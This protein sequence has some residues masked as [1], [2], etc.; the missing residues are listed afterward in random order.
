MDSDVGTTVHG[1]LVTNIGPRRVHRVRELVTALVGSEAD[2][3]RVVE[4]GGLVDVPGGP[5]GASAT[6]SPFTVGVGR[7]GGLDGS[8]GVLPVDSVDDDGRGGGRRGQGCGDGPVGTTIAGCGI[9]IP[10]CL[11]TCAALVE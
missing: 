9:H 4:Q 1:L 8:G 2:N 10:F 3:Q 5:V 6:C 7:L 11:T